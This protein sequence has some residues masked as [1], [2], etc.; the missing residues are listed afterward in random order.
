M[1]L[2]IKCLS[3][4]DS[5]VKLS[6]GK[7]RVKKKQV[8]MMVG[9][10]IITR[11]CHCPQICSVWLEVL[12][13]FWLLINLFWYVFFLWIKQLHECISV[14][15][16]SSSDF[17]KASAIFIG[18][19]HNYHNS[20]LI[21]DIFDTVCLQTDRELLTDQRHVFSTHNKQQFHVFFW[22]MG[23]WLSK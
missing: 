21:H 20:F 13:C 12:F 14:Y 6:L 8:E 4:C 3:V 2:S 7:A 1:V 11:M 18:I 19:D 9:Q 15:W 17:W 22:A 23:L 10:N 5:G 16:T